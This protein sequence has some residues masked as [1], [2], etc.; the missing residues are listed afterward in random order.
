MAKS[1]T[2]EIKLP[3]LSFKGTPSMFSGGKALNNRSF[4]KPSFV[5]PVVRVTQNKGGGGK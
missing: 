3:T 2:Q 4:N 1:K 5:P